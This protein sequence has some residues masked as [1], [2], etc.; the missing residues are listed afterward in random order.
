M[1]IFFES[2]LEVIYRVTYESLKV[3]VS[4]FKGSNEIH[5]IQME[6]CFNS[7]EFSLI[8]I[9]DDLEIFDR[10]DKSWIAENTGE[11]GEGTVLYF[12]D[13]NLLQSLTYMPGGLSL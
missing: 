11:T 5:Y 12:D 7:G 10:K 8:K 2:T 3:E 4:F 6:K 9:I 1:M 13:D